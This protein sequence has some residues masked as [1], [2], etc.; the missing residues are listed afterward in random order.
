MQ[1]CK[2]RLNTACLLYIKTAARV[3]V[4]H[5]SCHGAFFGEICFTIDCA[6]RRIYRIRKKTAALRGTAVLLSFRCRLRKRVRFAAE[7][8][9]VRP[10]P[11]TLSFSAAIGAYSRF[12]PRKSVVHR[13][14]RTGDVHAEKRATVSAVNRAGGK[15][16]SRFVSDKT[17][18]VVRVFAD[19]R[20]V[21]DRKSVV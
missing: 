9:A 19:F 17:R 12:Q 3:N 2:N 21:E 1:S 13:R 5:R 4:G 7:N 15:I 14:S 8:A 16:K 18:K 6:Y 10:S 20:A 11:R